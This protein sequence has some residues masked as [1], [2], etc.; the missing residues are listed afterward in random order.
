MEGSS[1]EAGSSQ[2]TD[3]TGREGAAVVYYSRTGHT[4]ALSTEIASLIDPDQVERIRPRSR[5]PYW[6]WLLRSFVPGSTVD[7]EPMPTDFRDASALFL[8]TPKWTVSCPP[9]NEFLD[10]ARIDVVPIGVFV[11]YGGFDERRYA[12][13]LVDRIETRGGDVRATLLVKDDRIGPDF[14]HGR[15]VSFCRSVLESR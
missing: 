3:S 5:R 10:R 12:E 11:T 15:V 2:S 13:T 14:D 1:G 8:G 7:I 9:V 4:H 6:S